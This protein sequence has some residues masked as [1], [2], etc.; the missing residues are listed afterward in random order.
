MGQI[1]Q[2]VYLVKICLLFS[3]FGGLIFFPLFSSYRAAP[4]DITIGIVPVNAMIPAGGPPGGQE[5]ILCPLG[6]P[7][8]SQLLCL[9]VPLC[10]TRTGGK[11]LSL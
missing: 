6:G 9:L 10:K 7:L 2:E 5:A 4:E 11:N 3:K 8:G 1:S